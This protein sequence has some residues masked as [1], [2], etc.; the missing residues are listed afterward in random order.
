MSSQ[1]PAFP[2]SGKNIIETVDAPEPVPSVV[3]HNAMGMDKDTERIYRMGQVIG[4]FASTLAL[5]PISVEITPDNQGDAPAW[6][7]A[8]TIYFP[9]KKI[10]DLT[11]PENVT[12]IRGLGLHESAHIMLTPRSG[13]NLFKEVQSRKLFRAFN[14]LED[15]RIETFMV[16]MFS[17]VDDWLMSTILRHMVDDP[18]NL[19][20]LFP[21]LH[22][23]KYIPIA[24]RN[25]VR[26]MY[27]KQA[28]VVELANLIDEYIQLNLADPKN[29]ARAIE[30]IARYSHLIDELDTSTSRYGWA[31]TGWNKVK[32]P[33]GHH[34]RKSVELKSSS[35]KPM[36]KSQQAAIAARV[37]QQ[38][39]K[40][41][42]GSTEQDDEMGPLDVL[43][44]NTSLVPGAPTN[45][46]S[47][48]GS[49]PLAQS[50]AQK[51]LDDIISS[52]AKDIRNTIKQFN[53]EV[54]LS[55]RARKAPK[56]PDWIQLNTVDAPTIQASKQFAREL[57]QLK[58]DYDPGWNRNTEFGKLSVERYVKG[59][60]LDECFDEW[61]MG[62]ED[63]VDI[64]CVM[65]LDNSGS[66]GWN[67]DGACQSMWAIKR[68]LDK[69]GAS[70]TVV[71]FSHT[72]ELLYSA[73]ER[74]EAKYRYSGMG[75]S[76]D[77]Y[78]SLMYAKSVLANSNKA[79]KVL[80][81]ITDGWWSDAESC[82]DLIRQMRMSGVITALGMIGS[83][84]G[85]NNQITLD[86][87]GCEVAV[88]V[89]QMPQLF[90]LAKD[91]V[92]VGIMRN[93]S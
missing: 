70:T 92:K 24:L 26:G 49:G 51:L 11:D 86:T 72:T 1:I 4:K 69:I 32:D 68:A 14:A 55:G 20:F 31:S 57:A 81:P 79:I 46:S 56:R 25:Q 36:T 58:A 47:T 45:G 17:N 84:R 8:E 53:G 19:P 75:N 93:L 85:I 52:R 67:M 15:Q 71:T 80:I 60:D 38:V 89:D 87:H 30:I 76:T 21:L 61:D 12:S 33:N 83:Y 28:D 74:A 7:D 39:A 6:S 59:V 88:A 23:R 65:L 37:A 35:N 54:E 41:Q 13:S 43:A 18:A 2:D 77:P 34:H 50:M 40:E 78:D 27:D 22:G 5:K 91:M 10:G 64:E 90:K 62:R 42:S 9:I 44:N 3:L 29:N 48:G 73:D 66:M 82:N 16:A 63:A